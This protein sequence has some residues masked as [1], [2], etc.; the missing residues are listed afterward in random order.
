MKQVIFF[1]FLLIS[2][3]SFGQR[4][5]GGA[6]GGE[7]DGRGAS[8]QRDTGPKP[9][10][11]AYK[12]ISGRGDTTYVDTT[13]TIQK[14]Y[15]FNYLRKDNFELVPFSNV[16]QTYNSLAYHIKGEDLIPEFGA[17]ARHFNFMEQEDISY[18]EVPTPFTEVYF[19]TVPEQGQTLDAFFTINTSPRLNFSAAYKGLRS[20]GKY[21]HQLTSTGNFRA[22]LNYN[23]LN[24]RYRIKTHFVSQDLLNQENG[25]LNDQALQQYVSKEIEFEDRSLLEVKFEDAEN[26]LFGKRFYL[27]QEYDLVKRE[28]NRITLHHILDFSDKKYIFRQASAASDVFGETF[29]SSNLRDQVKYRHI[30]NIAAVS[31]ENSTLGTLTGKAGIS[32]YNYGY[33]SILI[34]DENEVITNRLV[35]ENYSAGVAYTNNFGAFRIY[36]DA[37][38]NL[39]GDFSGHY[40][41]AG[42]GYSLN[43]NNSLS[44]EINSNERAPNFN[45]LLNQSDYFDYNWQIDFENQSLRSLSLKLDSKNLL[46]LDAA[47][48]QID[49][50]AYFSRNEEGAIK[51]FQFNGTVNYVKLK[52]GREFS[53]GKFSL[54]NTLM[55]QTVTSGA[56]VFKVPAFVTR[57]SLY[58]SDHLFRRALFL[59]TGFTLKYFTPYEMNGYDPVLAEFYVQNDQELGGYPIVDFFLNARIRQTRIFFKLEHVNSLIDGNN[60]FVAPDYPH[61][62]FLVR[63]GLVWNFFL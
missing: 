30:N 28:D 36:G 14:D 20:L 8:V 40:L 61:R 59:Q 17:R 3:S 60:N 26:V 22:T 11:T 58:F 31:Y 53:Y 54:D 13:L 49:Q 39:L 19:K 48:S 25:G 45:F 23:T 12:I 34:L 51:P 6:T 29:R 55:Y 7:G 4:K 57:N 9:P 44:A 50:Y 21:Q 62:D 16:G 27:D 5:L 10:I 35:G 24:E 42:A 32:Y 33:N 46:Q 37:M 1:C 52:A 43:E 38:V 63:F 47:V 18:Y 56:E 41:S 15:K 2:I